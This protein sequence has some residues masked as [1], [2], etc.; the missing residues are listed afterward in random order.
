M[1]QAL[2]QSLM[3]QFISDSLAPINVPRFSEVA[4]DLALLVGREGA[5]R[6]WVS[7]EMETG[8][9]SLKHQ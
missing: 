3:L 9:M 6:A 1:R 5:V 4:Q 8:S 2:K 7:V